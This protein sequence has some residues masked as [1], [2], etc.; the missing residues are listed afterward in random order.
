MDASATARRQV[1]HAE[2]RSCHNGLPPLLVQCSW[3]FAHYPPFGDGSNYQGVAEQTVAAGQPCKVTLPGSMTRQFSNLKTG[4]VYYYSPN[5]PVLSS[6]VRSHGHRQ[7][8]FSH[9]NAGLVGELI[10]TTKLTISNVKI[11]ESRKPLMILSLLQRLRFGYFFSNHATTGGLR[12]ER[13]A[14]RRI[15]DDLKAHCPNHKHPRIL[16]S[17]QQFDF[18]KGQSAKRPDHHCRL[19]R[20][21]RQ[22][23]RTAARPA[24]R[25][26]H[27]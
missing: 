7:S 9:G 2:R 1:L 17:A 12:L 10:R 23:R 24:A 26:Q 6:A 14:A 25:I 21:E 8:H 3:Q 20:A 11:A 19:H 15:I 22:R 5:G 16:A 27:S 4:R 13:P 18:L